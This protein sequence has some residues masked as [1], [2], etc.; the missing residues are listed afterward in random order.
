MKDMARVQPGKVKARSNKTRCGLSITW[1]RLGGNAR[2]L[3]E[4]TLVR[5]EKDEYALKCCN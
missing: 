3:D 5:Q 4:E 2:K 1:V